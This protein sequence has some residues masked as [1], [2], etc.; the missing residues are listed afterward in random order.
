MNAKIIQ[1]KIYLS[2]LFFL[3]MGRFIDLNLPNVLEKYLFPNFSLYFF[4]I[5]L[6]ILIISRVKIESPILLAWRKLY[7]F[8][9]IYS[10]LMAC[11]L[12]VP[13]GIL[14]GENT[15]QACAGSIVFWFIVLC[16]LYYN[17]YCIIYIVKPQQIIKTIHKSAIILLLIGYIQFFSIVFSGPFS[18]IY[19]FLS[20][21][22]VLLP[23]EKL[24]RGVVFWGSEPS[25]ASIILIY[26][27]P[28]MLALIIKPM[29]KRQRSKE[30]IMLILFLPLFFSSKSSTVLIIVIILI[31]TVLSILTQ[32]KWIYKLLLVSSLCVGIIIA[33][34]Y[35]LENYSISK[36]EDID[37]NS[38]EYLVFDKIKD[39]NNL[40]TMMRS[41]TIIND[42]K[43]FMDFPITGI[44]DGLQGY[45]YNENIPKNFLISEEVSNVYNGEIGVVD[46]GG[47]FF[48]CFISAYGIIGLFF[49]F[50]VLKK[51]LYIF[52]INWKNLN[53]YDIM[54][55]LFLIIFCSS[56]WFS[57]GIRQN[58]PIILMLILPITLTRKCN[59]LK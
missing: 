24:D 49:L 33:F 10:L 59:G 57:I 20:Q 54:L 14:H 17:Y 43:I 7:I 37:K 3:P 48:P 5:G 19:S 1:E 39:V 2:Y 36:N 6:L 28:M 25:S 58:F 51:Y 34:S 4:F 55:M 22:F 56:A 31:T 47:A 35:G 11:F 38:W 41:S 53:A 45:F 44:G 13:F 40:S 12:F 26:L 9:A 32:K 30:L 27:I 15:F 29:H 46:G 42:I 21:L 50:P 52:K 18:K 23:I 16:H 8:Q